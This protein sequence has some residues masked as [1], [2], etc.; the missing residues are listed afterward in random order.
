MVGERSANQRVF[1][2]ISRITVFLSS[3]CLILLA[4]TAFLSAFPRYLPIELRTADDNRQIFANRSRTISVKTKSGDILHWMSERIRPVEENEIL[5]EV[6]YETDSNGFRIPAM[7]SEA[8][9]IVA[10]DDSF[11]EAQITPTPWTD[12]LASELATPVLNLGI[13]GYGTRHQADALANF[14]PDDP[15]W[16]LIAFFEGNDLRDLEYN[17]QPLGLRTDILSDYII[18]MVGESRRNSA[19][20]SDNRIYPVIVRVGDFEYPLVFYEPLLWMLNAPEDAYRASRNL[21][22]FQ[23]ALLRISN[24]ADDACVAL[25]YMPTKAHVFLPFTNAEDQSLIVEM[26]H[27][28]QPGGGGWLTLVPEASPSPEVLLSRLD[29]QKNV[30][31]DIATA[32][33]IP[34]FDL[35]PEFRAAAMDGHQLYYTYD[36]HLDDSGQSVAGHAIADFLRTQEDCETIDF[37]PQNSS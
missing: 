3:V 10:L 23:N 37:P 9:P 15:D 32:Q 4:L 18:H 11:T 21:D 34:F 17:A 8:Y 28:I 36:T 5:A 2:V 29:N 14:G 27:T 19:T 33:G 24:L 20:E 12:Y 22:E 1:K 6:L 7:V 31:Q 13:S 30:I 25:I 16:V 35:T 26:S